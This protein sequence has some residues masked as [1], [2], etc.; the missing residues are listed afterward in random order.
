MRQEP[1]ASANSTTNQP[2]EPTGTP[3][4]NPKKEDPKRQ[5][6]EA[7][8]D[9]EKACLMKIRENRARLQELE[10]LNHINT[11]PHSPQRS[12]NYDQA[13]HSPQQSTNNCGIHTII[14]ILTA[15]DEILLEKFNTNFIEKNSTATRAWLFS[16][17]ITPT[18]RQAWD[19]SLLKFIR[20]PPH[21][22]WFKI[23]AS[24]TVAEQDK[25][26]A[27]STLLPDQYLSGDATRLSLNALQ[28]EPPIGLYVFD[29][30]LSQITGADRTNRLWNALWRRSREASTARLRSIILPINGQNYHWY[31]AILHVGLTQCRMEICT[32][33]NIR[34]F[35]A[36]QTLTEIGNRY[37]SQWKPPEPPTRPADKDETKVVSPQRQRG[38]PTVTPVRKPKPGPPS[39]AP[40]SYRVMDVPR[41]GHCLFLACIEA[42]AHNC[43]SLP[44]AWLSAPRKDQHKMMRTAL[45]RTCRNEFYT[46][47]KYR[48][49]HEGLLAESD[50]NSGQTLLFDMCENGTQ[51][52]IQKSTGTH[53]H[54]HTIAATQYITTG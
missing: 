40:Q 31:I 42:M 13:N 24:K 3:A 27:L 6:D 49:L 5:A 20:A 33:A 43:L 10:A 23:S 37:L 34:N 48:I 39:H 9:Y 1:K 53:Q 8:S 16:R 38:G 36:E 45:L 18:T 22:Q 19:Q 54:R 15:H 51:E 17:L 41:D 21:D 32:D 44:P 25:H 2:P 35:A 46:E 12:T 11:G 28:Y 30:L 4:P 14:R 7:L 47:P 26:K 29:T 52:W 50:P